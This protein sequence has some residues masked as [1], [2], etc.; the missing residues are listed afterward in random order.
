MNRTAP[1]NWLSLF[2]CFLVFIKSWSSD[3]SS[4]S[5]NGRN[6]DKNGISFCYGT[7]NEKG[8]ESFYIYYNNDTSKFFNDKYQ[9]LWGRKT[10]ISPA[11]FSLGWGVARI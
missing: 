5:V 3:F 7:F 10:K 11:E 6:T 2:F 9:A 1:L 8:P 4:H